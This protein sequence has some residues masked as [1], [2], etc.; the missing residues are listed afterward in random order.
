MPTTTRA[1]AWRCVVVLKGAY[2]VVA[3]PDGRATVIPFA[4]AALA[5]AGTGDVLAGVIV[6]LL[7]QGVAPYHAALCGAYLHAVAGELWRQA[8]GA[9]GLLASDLLPLLPE[10]MRRLRA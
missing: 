1:A 6:G 4:N 7:A 9:A 8:H 10:A 2:S 5:T 3:S